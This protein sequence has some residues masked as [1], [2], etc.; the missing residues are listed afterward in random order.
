MVPLRLM[1][2][3]V[4]ASLLAAWP[5]AAQPLTTKTVNIESP[6]PTPLGQLDFPFTH[7]FSLFGSKVTSS[8]TFT[9]STGLTSRTSAALRYATNSDVNSLQPGAFNEW[10][11][12]LKVMGLNQA[13]GAPIDLTALLAYN[14][15]ASSTDAA[16]VFARRW[17]PVSLL[18]TLKGFSNGYGM[19]A[20]TAAGAGLRWDL[21][22]FLQV[23]ADL[24]GVSSGAFAGRGAPAWSV[25]TT[26]EIPYTPHSVSLYMT[27]ANTHTL[28]GTS[29]GTSQ[30]RGGFEFL[31]PFTSWQRW[32]A[33]FVP[34]PEPQAV[35][36]AQAASAS[37]DVPMT[38]VAGETIVAI[39]GMKYVPATV[40]VAPG[41]TVRW[42]NR[43]SME[44]TVTSTEGKWDSGTI[45]PGETWSRRF[46]EPGSYPYVCTPHPFM[47]G[48]VVVR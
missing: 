3:I 11:A 47:T 37:A 30:V 14:T 45:R 19:G 13:Q 10:E 4:A 43:D 29:H 16:L 32:A 9:L 27:N 36:Q 41:S 15:A 5:L 21:T 8:P 48:T 7:R 12:L 28:Q 35:Q 44:H 20:A 31:V 39:Q 24:N 22:R 26:F 23:S 17:G 34:P 46:D 33:I 42:V 1:G 2:M 40:T 18:G 25:G 6:D 38:V